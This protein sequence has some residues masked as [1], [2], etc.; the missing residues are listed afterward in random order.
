M[1]VCDLYVLYAALHFYTITS[2]FFSS[3]IA[4]HHLEDFLRSQYKEEVERN[5]M[6]EAEIEGGRPLRPVLGSGQ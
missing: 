2:Q 5:R 6:R 4:F 1:S 3:H